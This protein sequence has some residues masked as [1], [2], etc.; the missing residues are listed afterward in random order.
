MTDPAVIP[1]DRLIVYDGGPEVIG[2]DCTGTG[3]ITQAPAQRNPTI[4]VVEDP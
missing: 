3:G 2:G 1:D 4:E